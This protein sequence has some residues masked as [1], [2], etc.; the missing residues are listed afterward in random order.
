MRD[1]KVVVTGGL[2]FIGSHLVERL[3]DDNDVTV[4]D[5]RSTGSLDNVKHLLDRGLTVV[6]GDVSTIDLAPLFEDK[7]YVFHLAALPSVP[8]SISDPMRSHHANLTGTLNVLTAA[9]DA[10]VRKVV[11]ASSSSVYGD[12]PT[13]P[14]SEDMPL[15]PKSPYAVTKAAGEMYCTTFGEVYGLKS[16]SLRYFNVFGPRQDPDSPYAAVIPRFVRAM[17]DDRSPFVYG[18]GEQ[19][20]DFT[21]VRHVVDATIKACTSGQTGI[22]NVACGRSITLNQLI[23]MINELLSKDIRPVY[24]QPRP[25]DI[26]HSVADISKA[27]R[28]HYVPAS[29]FKEELRETVGDLASC[30]N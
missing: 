17:L 29:D 12:A 30:Q 8:R 16:I 21:Y 19:S 15:S 1:R 22:F 18:N 24:L 2:G 26:M 10:G 7:D 28:F 6:D 5:D 11:F 25:G 14:K 13:L 23:G 27:G 9:K 3:I 4:I 20:R